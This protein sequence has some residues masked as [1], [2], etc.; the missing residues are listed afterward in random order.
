[1]VELL[2]ISKKYGKKQI[3]NDITF[4]VNCGECVA[5]VGENG[6]GKSTL[7][8]IMAG[9]MQPNS[10]SI[11]YFEQDLVHNKK[12]FKKYCGYVPQDNPLMEELTVKD[13]L[14]LWGWDLKHPNTAVAEQFQL[15]DIMN[16]KVATLSG[17]MKRR[18][19]IACALLQ[20]PPIVLLD[21]PTTALDIFYKENVQTWIAQ[22]RK[23][24]GIVVM[25]THDEGEIMNAD[26]CLVMVDGKLEDVTDL[27]VRMQKIRNYI[28]NKKV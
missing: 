22:Y 12:L 24:N 27:N 13:N 7:L 9:I 18:L 26:R 17:G 25:T 8:Q 3:L 1:M 4:R 23:R 16:K 2:H 14:L 20:N 10:G 6:C 19:S 21:E 15:S 28:I 5:I 11:R